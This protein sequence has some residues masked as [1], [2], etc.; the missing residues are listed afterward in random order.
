MQYVAFSA[1]E[2]GVQRITRA[3]ELARRAVFYDLPLGQHQHAI[4][5]QG[6]T[7]VVRDAEKARLREARPRTLQQL[8]PQGALQAPKWLVEQRQAGVSFE[9]GASEPHSLPLPARQ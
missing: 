2:L 1:Q 4:E 9:P 7:H 8:T 6:F 3:Q 5:L